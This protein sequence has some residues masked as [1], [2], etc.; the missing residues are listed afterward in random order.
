M[1]TSYDHQP[2]PPRFTRGRSASHSASGRGLPPG[3]VFP[4]TPPNKPRPGA[5]FS[6]MNGDPRLLWVPAFLHALNEGTPVRLASE[7][8]GISYVSAYA[9]RKE[10]QVFA[11]MWELALQK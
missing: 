5:L 6:V 4:G 9:L 3:V 2:P 1:L 7:E 10:D 8:A 11:V